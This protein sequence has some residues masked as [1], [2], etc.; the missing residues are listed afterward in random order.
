[1]ASAHQDPVNPFLK[2]GQDEEGVHPS[3]A[4]HANDPDIRR[5]LDPAG[6]GKIRSCIAAPVAEKS[7]DFGFPFAAFRHVSPK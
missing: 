1:M 7:H 2:T 5:I 6:T 3:G 4:G